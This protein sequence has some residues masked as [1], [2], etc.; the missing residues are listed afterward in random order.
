[1]KLIYRKAAE[2]IIWPG[3]PRHTIELAIWSVEELLKLT[4]GKIYSTLPNLQ[5]HK[6]GTANDP[7]PEKVR[8]SWRVVRDL[9]DIPYWKRVWVIQEISIAHKIEI[10]L[11]NIASHG[12]S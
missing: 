8:E 10:Y 6:V 2:V 11:G 3:I 7:L 4:P 1:M 9:F 5:I 12:K